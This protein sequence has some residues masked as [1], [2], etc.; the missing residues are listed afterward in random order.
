MEIWQVIWKMVPTELMDPDEDYETPMDGA[1]M[2][3]QSNITG[4]DLEVGLGAKAHDAAR[5]AL[6]DE[7]LVA[8]FAGWAWTKCELIR[9]FHVVFG[10]AEEGEA[11]R[12]ELGAKW[13]HVCCPPHTDPTLTWDDMLTWGYVA[14]DLLY[15]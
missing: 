8:W 9:R 12:K 11:V 1:P 7:K 15:R 5:I 13:N 4:F 10:T 2:V 6:N 3:S 14:V